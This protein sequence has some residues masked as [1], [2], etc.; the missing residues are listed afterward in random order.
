MTTWSR[1]A[2]IS[3]LV[4]PDHKLLS[5]RWKLNGATKTCPG[6]MRLSGIFGL[7]RPTLRG[8]VEGSVIKFSNVK[9]W[10][11]SVCH[12]PGAK[13]LQSCLNGFVFRFNLRLHR[14]AGL[15][16]LLNPVMKSK[17]VPCKM[18]TSSEQSA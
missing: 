8:V 9:A 4:D 15:K 1:A 18:L 7:H 3:A 5:G 10:K 14:H 6:L 12:D 17:P 2:Y 13:H 16:S 11:I